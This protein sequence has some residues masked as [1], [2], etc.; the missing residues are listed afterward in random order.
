MD[1]N[2]KH[3]MIFDRTVKVLEHLIHLSLQFHDIYNGKDNSKFEIKVLD[4]PGD[5]MSLEFKLDE[6]SYYS[7]IG[8]EYDVFCVMGVM[9]AKFETKILEH[10]VDF[11]LHDTS[12]GIVKEYVAAYNRGFEALIELKDSDEEYDDKLINYYQIPERREV[13]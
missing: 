9:I 7:S 1:K 4:Y 8:T 5:L 11:L 10:M 12:A 3:Y 13:C 6:H 2:H